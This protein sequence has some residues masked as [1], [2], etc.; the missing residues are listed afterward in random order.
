MQYDATSPED[1]INQVPVE[2]Q[3]T[4]KKLR[5]VIN[6]NLPKGFEEGIQYKM[7]GYY[8]PH[9]VY[10]NGYHCDPKTPLPFMSFASQKNSIN[11]YHMGMYAKK[12]LLD[13]FVNEYPKHCKRKLDMGKSCIR[14]K[15]MDEIP[16][17]LIGE[18]TQKMSSKEWIDIY[19]SA[20]KK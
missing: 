20:I 10:P 7:I 14:F 6:D 1:Y 16:F 11:L 9:S 4:L 13:W 2:R 5:Q 8:V 15:N 3:E 19:E 17:E 18:L 12:E